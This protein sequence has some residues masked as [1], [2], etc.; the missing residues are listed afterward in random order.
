[1]AVLSTAERSVALWK[2]NAS[3]CETPSSESEEEAT[4]T[5]EVSAGGKVRLDFKVEKHYI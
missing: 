4:R 2:P 5:G 1:M 3:R